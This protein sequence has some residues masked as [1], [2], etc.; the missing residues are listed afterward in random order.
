MKNNNKEWSLD[1]TFLQKGILIFVASW[2]HGAYLGSLNS[3]RNTFCE[4]VKIEI[5]IYYTIFF[6]L[7]LN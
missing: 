2:L 1:E 3:E 6:S 7:D 5:L 4:K